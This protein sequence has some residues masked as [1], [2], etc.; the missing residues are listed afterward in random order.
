MN[1]PFSKMHGLGNDF[2]VFDN[3]EIALELTP[4]MVSQWGDRQWGVGFDQLL[5][6]E[7]PKSENAH[8]SYR[9]FNADGREVEHCG[10]GARCFARFV[11]NQK[12]TDLKTIIVDT[13]KDQLELVVND[14][15]YVTVMMGVPTFEPTEIPLDANK[16]E[17]YQVTHDTA[18]DIA[19]QAVAISN[20]HA[21]L[22]VES[23]N[24]AAVETIGPFLES[25]PIF[26]NKVNVGFMRVQDR[27]N[28]DLRVFERGVGETQACGSGACA[29]AIIGMQNGVLD[30]TVTAHLVGGNLEISWAGIG[31]PVYMKGPAVEVFRGEIKVEG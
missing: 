21:V 2:M 23:V 14:D 20:P 5:V 24:S 29:A 12:L 7:Q 15:G 3:S 19:F 31:Q 30:S 22:Q 1:L 25:H 17:Q 4:L 10:N 26:P 18:G 13:I 16:A 6:V 27:Q 9:I 8:F 11:R 28:F